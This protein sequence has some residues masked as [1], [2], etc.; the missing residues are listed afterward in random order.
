MTTTSR[1]NDIERF[2]RWSRTYEDSWMQKHFFDRVH[3]AVL[4]LAANGVEPETI[5]DVGCGTGRLLRAAG[6]R[7]PHAALIG[8]DAAEGMVEVARSLTP[9]A[10]F[11]VAIAEALPLPDASVDLALSTTSFHHWSDQ[12]AGIREVARVLRPEGRFFLADI[13]GPAL[14]SK[15]LHRSRFQSP[16]HVRTL[17]TDAG[18]RVILQKPVVSRFVL[19]TAASS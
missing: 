12:T 16:A 18:L 2:S 17:F 19:V 7:W 9:G 4:T 13:A 1:K 3:E 5:L 15:L 8:V 10:T 14:L 6:T 11:Y